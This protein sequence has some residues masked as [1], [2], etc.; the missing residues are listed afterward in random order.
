M[1]TVF[2]KK[3]QGDNKNNQKTVVKTLSIKFPKQ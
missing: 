2:S 1:K 3:V